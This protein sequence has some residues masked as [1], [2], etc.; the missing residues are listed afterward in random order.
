VDAEAFEETTATAR[1]SREP[2]AYRTAIELYAGDFL[3]EDRYEEWTEDRRQE[4]SQ[5]YLAL[6]V[7]LA[8]LYEEREEYGRG[9]EVLR[10]VL[11]EEPAREEAHA[12][13]MRL[14]ILSGRRQEAIQQYERMRKALSKELSADP[15]AE[16]RR[17]YQEIRAGSFQATPPSSGGPSEKLV[18]SA[19]H[20]LPSPLTTFVGREREMVETKR[21]L[22]MTRLLTFTG[23][24]GS[25]KTRLAL[26][27]ARDLLGAYPDGA[28]LVELAPLSEPDLLPQAVGST[29][30]V[31]EQQ[32]R[33][34]LETLLDALSDKEMLLVLD[35]CEHLIDAAAHT[36]EALL[37]ACPRLRVLAT[38][39]KPLGI[40]GEVLWQVRPLSLPDAAERGPDG[41][42]SSR[43]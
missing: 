30:E 34:L 35:N 40:G 9:I 26:E 43:T 20:N 15:S 25:G 18:D 11:S 22:A 17:L 32:G 5:L 10:R 6:L 38:G 37:R 42:P 14:Y 23:A 8:G 4:L 31:H 19:R 3:P 21:L 27:V 39:R 13:L 2:A 29:L 36:S 16:S 33:P 24:G 12:S 41:G 1:R 28:W 7:E